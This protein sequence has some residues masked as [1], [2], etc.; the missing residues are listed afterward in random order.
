MASSGNFCTLNQIAELGQST[1]AN[2][3]AGSMSNGNLKYVNL[4]NNTAVG[5]YALT[6]GKWYFEVYI[7]SF[8]ADNG[9]TIGFSNHLFNLDAE[10]GYNSP[11]SSTGA[12]AFGYYA[13]TN[14]LIYG[15]GDGGSSYNKTWGG[16][17]KAT[18]GDIIQLY[19]DVD[20]LKFWAGKNN[21]VFNSGNPATGTGRGF[22]TGGDPHNIAILPEGGLYPAIGNWSAAD[23]TVTFNFGQDSTFGGEITAAGNTDS[24]GFGDFKYEPPSGFLAICSA[25]LPI[26]ADVDPAETDSDYPAKQFNVVNWTG[27]GTAQSIT[28][29]GFAPDLVWL[30]RRDATADH[31]LLDTTRGATYAIESSTTANSST[32]VTDGLTAFGTDGFTL[33]T[34][35]DYNGN[36]NTYTAWC[37][38]ANGGTTSTNTSGTITSTVQANTAAG[39]SIV[40]WRSNNSANQTIGHGLSK[41]PRFIISKPYSASTWSWHNFHHYLG[42]IGKFNFAGSA[43]GAFGSG[44]NTYGAMPSETVFTVGT[45]GNLMPNN[46][47]TDVI[48]YCWHDVDGMQKF[49]IYKGNGSA[50]GPFVYLGF[51][52]RLFVQKRADSTGAWRVWDSERHSFNPNDAIF[53]S[54]TDGA[55]DTANGQVDFLSNGVKI[56]MTYAEMNADGGTFIYMAWGDVP[57]KYSN[58][59]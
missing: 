32:A 54:G 51:R 2:T 45:A 48:S 3:R 39:F 13:Q 19:L 24:N 49:G 38:R 23:A 46:S 6:S 14:K 56:R 4:S 35:T 28:G 11:G 8:N 22:G 1:D 18:D 7:N 5:T 37:W 55:E 15:P 57:Y 34:N 16:G 25:N 59:L 10:L 12:Q 17:T 44:T 29:V 33:G 43:T 9:M 31:Q 40:K 50:D 58:P 47:T 26:S 41:A 53:R 20:N 36:T 27:T 21:T 42:S 52:P 30:K